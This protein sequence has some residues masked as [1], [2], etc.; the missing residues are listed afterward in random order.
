MSS[1][2]QDLRIFRQYMEAQGLPYHLENRILI[3]AE[4]VM[5]SVNDRK[6]KK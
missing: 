5:R 6:K 1:V 4:K 2:E 3:E